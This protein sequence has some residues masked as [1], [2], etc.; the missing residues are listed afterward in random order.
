MNIK[1]AQAGTE[2]AERVADV[3]LALTHAD[4]D[5]GVSAISRRLGLSKAVVHRILQSLT[6]RELA[7]VDPTTRGYGLGP[8]AIALGARALRRS[9]LRTVARE[10]LILLRN[11]TQETTTLSLLVGD[12]RAYIDQ[13]EG[14]QEIK[15]TVEPGRLYSLHAGASSRA[16]LAFLPASHIQNVLSAGLKPL[17]DETIQD[18]DELFE[19]LSEVRAKHFA[20][21]QGERQSGAGSVASPVFQSDGRVIGSISVCGPITRFD[22]ASVAD[23]VPKVLAAAN[24]IS[25]SLGWEVSQGPPRAR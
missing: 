16:I 11:A 12:Q 1:S 9:E 14:P 20:V 19:K 15:M 8:S 24:R 7:R 10:E 17:T 13:Y 23:H 4:G 5:I 21:S 3:L 2:S 6:S 18:Q 25:A 22:P